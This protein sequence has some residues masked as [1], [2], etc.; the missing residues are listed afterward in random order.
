MDFGFL[1]IDALKNIWKPFL[2]PS[3]TAKVEKLLEEVKNQQ[4]KYNDVVDS[5]KLEFLKLFDLFR[6]QKSQIVSKIQPIQSTGNIIRGR[7][8]KIIT[9]SKQKVVHQQMQT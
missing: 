7:N 8:N 2:E 4:I 3:F 6:A 1:L 5:I 9:S